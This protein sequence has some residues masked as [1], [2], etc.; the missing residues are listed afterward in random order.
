M[1][2][3]EA[4]AEAI[5][6]GSDC[7]M[8]VVFRQFDED[9]RSCFLEWVERGEYPTWISQ[10]LRR[11]RIAVGEKLIR[12]HLAGEC[13]CLPNEEDASYGIRKP[14]ERTMSDGST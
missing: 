11:A 10:T 2:L 3:R 6:I 13:I 9:D 5:Q 4:E 8:A 14:S 12:A 1:K 7:K